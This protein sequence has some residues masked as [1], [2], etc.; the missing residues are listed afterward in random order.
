MFP[1]SIWLLLIVVVIMSS[2]N[3]QNEEL[4]L[5]DGTTLYEKKGNIFMIILTTI[6]LIYF[7]ANTIANDVHA[8]RINFTNINNSLTPEILFKRGVGS[9]PLFAY[10]Q[11]LF[12]KF[13]STNPANFQLLVALIV[14]TG[15]MIFFRRYS[16]L[17][18]MTIFMFITSGLFYFSIVSWKQ[19]IAMAIGLISI[20]LILEKKYVFF[21]LILLI[22]MFIH[23]Y[24]IV[25]G[26]F[27]FIINQ[28]VWTK[29]N[30][31]II[32]IMWLVGV[33]LS[34]ILGSALEITENVFGDVHDAKYFTEES[35][36]SFQRVI[37]F[38]IT[39]VLSYIYRNRIDLHPY[40]LMNGFI[41]MSVISFGF[42]LMAMYGGANFIS[43][44]GT[45]FEPFTYVA[46]PYILIYIVP[47]NHKD[48]IK[49]GVMS[50][51]LIF[52]AFLQLKVNPL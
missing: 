45:Y 7:S 26:I 40:P 11:V 18:P 38:A 49:Y 10:F 46:L 8:Y 51:F 37:F 1:F 36:V 17:L 43:R 4:R 3:L 35:G 29:K 16:P 5:N 6:I 44:M 2:L 9:N 47:Q 34:K 23:P 15:Y 33:F 14:Q 27:P 24:I 39:P 30:I 48:I 41:Q 42:M 28:K 52:F 21:Y 31:L 20:P 32:I 50:I 19:S 13:I 12:K 25:Y 22:T